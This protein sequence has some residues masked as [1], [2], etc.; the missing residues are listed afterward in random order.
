MLFR[1]YIGIMEK[2]MAAP[3]CRFRVYGNRVKGLVY[4]VFARWDGRQVWMLP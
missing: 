1:G 4:P 3:I 2:K